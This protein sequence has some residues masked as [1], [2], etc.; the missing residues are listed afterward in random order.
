[1]PTRPAPAIDVGLGNVPPSHRPSTTLNGP[2]IRP[3]SST[4]CSGSASE[5][6]RV[7]LLS[8][9]HTT[10]A[11]TIASGPIRPDSVG[12]PVHARIPAPATRQAQDALLRLA[13]QASFSLPPH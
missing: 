11:P 10:Q 13:V 4:I 9:P 6:L 3:F 12:V 8:R 5:T 1:M 7:R 2:A